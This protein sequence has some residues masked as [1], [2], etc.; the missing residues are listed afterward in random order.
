MCEQS[1]DCSGEVQGT[2]DIW[3]PS[4]WFGRL[5]S[6]SLQLANDLRDSD[7]LKELHARLAMNQIQNQ[8][9]FDNLE[10]NQIQAFDNLKKNQF[11]AQQALVTDIERLLA[12]SQ[13]SATLRSSDT[14]VQRMPPKPAVF[15]GRDDIIEEI[16]QL[17]MK[18]ETSRI[19]ILGPGG[20][21][22]TSVSLG[23]VEQP[24]IKARFLPENRV[25]VP[26]IEATS[27]TLLLE[28]L[29]TQLQ[30]P[31]DKQVTIETI[32]SLLNTSTQPRLILLDNFETPYNALGGTQSQVEDILCQLAMLSHVAILV[33]M[34]GRYPPC[35]DT[36]KW[37]SKNIKPTDE[38]ACLRIYHRIYPDS[39]NDGDLS[40]LLGVLG[41]M[42][43]AITLMAKLAKEARSSAKELLLAWS[44]DGPDILPDYYEQSMNRSISLSVDSN[45][46]RK[47]PQALLLLKILACLPAGTAKETFRWWVPATHISKVPSAIATLLKAG[48]LVENERQGS[49]TPVLFV[50]PV[51]Q[52]FMQQ[53]GRIEEEIWHNILSS[54]YQY[55]LDHSCR[56][57]DP[58][59]PIKSKALAAEDI[60]IQAILYGSPIMQHIVLS[61][62]A[63]EALTAFSWY[64]CDTKPNLEFAKH[65]VSMAKAFGIKKHIA[66]TSFCLGTTYSLLGEFHAA[67]DH[68]MEAYQLFR[69]LLPGD[70]ELERL[71]CQCGIYLI[72]AARLIFGFED[73][74]MV[75]SLARDVE[76]RSA[77]I[78]DD[79]IHGRSLI[80]LGLVLRR[81]QDPKESLCHLERGKVKVTGSIYFAEACDSIAN[82]YYGMDKL[83]EAL[84]AVKEGWKH[85]E[86]RNNLKDQA[87]ISIT[88]SKILFSANRDAE[89]WNY[90]EIALMKNSHLGNRRDSGI[91]LDYMGYGYL[92]RGD[93]LNAYGAY[94]AAAESYL[95]TDLEELEGNRCK[96]NM[97]L[98]RNKQRD[99]DLNIGFKRP[100]IDKDWL[101]LFYPGVQDISE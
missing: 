5:T 65:A 73:Y 39:E 13:Q 88:F 27:A 20:M 74:H 1:L 98:I 80:M 37:Q 51:V 42:P 4:P 70:H 57:Y 100:C 33:T 3:S 40:R 10:K 95:G 16:S 89:A 26:C 11:Q 72:D 8:Q 86:L 91:A 29:Y 77:T 49:D 44:K 22:K 43:F 9:A 64:R 78:S 63:I 85:A 52:S 99:P 23:I 93:Y 66:S 2:S 96:D 15:H 82:V 17:L 6:S 58:A 12:K 36:I 75:V 24:L 55:V 31:R 101:S 19:C 81:I 79:L 71:C 18:E 59:F 83:P 21:G 50:L 32:I 30:L 25:W 90:I 45:L 68:L 34:R 87:E 60:N 62:R 7:L 54:C 41:H 97:A 84:D 47:N 14:V 61:D 48:L 53:R 67:Y 69:A 92:R 94:E 28:I 76:K 38:A 35:D 56:E 46:M